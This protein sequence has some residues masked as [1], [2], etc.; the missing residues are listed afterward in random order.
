M[1][2]YYELCSEDG[3]GRLVLKRIQTGQRTGHKTGQNTEQ[4]TEQNTGP[5]S[6]VTMPAHVSKSWHL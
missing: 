6:D 5:Q 4:N 2:A 3:K 1:A